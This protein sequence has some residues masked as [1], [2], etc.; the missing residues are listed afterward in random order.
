MILA[1]MMLVS[2][3]S[4]ATGAPAEPP[5]PPSPI[6][7]SV[8]FD[9]VSSIVR[10]AVGSDNWPI[11]WADDGHMYTSYGDGWGFEPR[12]EKKLSQGFARIVGPATD[13]RGENVRSETG[14]TVGDGARGPKA[15]GMLMVDGV[16]Y[17][18]VRNTDNSQITWSSDHA[19]TWEWGF[20][21]TTDFG[22]PTLLNFGRNYEGA[23]DDYVYTYSQDGPSAY[24]AYDRVV[25]ARVPKDRIRDRSAYDFFVKL[26]ERGQPAWSTD[27]NKRGAIFSHPGKCRRMDVVYNPAL[28]RY[29]MIQGFDHAS[30]FGIFDAPEPW[31]PWTTAFYTEGWDLQQAH[32]YRLPSKWIREDGCTMYL[33]FCCT[34]RYDAFTVRKLTLRLTEGGA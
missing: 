31:G 32:G 16:L 24:E 7:K 6:I 13:F 30:G 25:L 23:R 10:K 27:I 4:A 15:S 20:K 14:E 29:I 12:T 8:T 19:K 21:F 26:D 22:C 34:G 1:H 33:V 11:T 3:L 5:Y 17:M 28:K 18:W 9:P 2:L